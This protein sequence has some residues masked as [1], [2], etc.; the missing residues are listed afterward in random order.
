[1]YLNTTKTVLHHCYSLKVTS[2]N[3]SWFISLIQRATIVS[4]ISCTLFLKVTKETIRA[5]GFP[6]PSVTQQQATVSCRT[7]REDWWEEGAGEVAHIACFEEKRDAHRQPLRRRWGLL[8]VLEGA[9]QVSTSPLV[10]H[11]VSVHS[12]ARLLLCGFRQSVKSN[13]SI[14]IFYN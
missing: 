9:V 13:Y 11:D 6:T 12:Y 3:F 8:L 14:E 4:L 2:S 7:Y 5:A 1:M 10:L